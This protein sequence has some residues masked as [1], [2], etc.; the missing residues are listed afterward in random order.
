MLLERVLQRE[1]VHHRR[2]HAHIVGGRAVEALGRGGHAAEDVAAADDEAQ[3]MALRLRRCDLAGEAGDRFGIDAELA[4]AH[5]RLARQLQQDAVEARAGHAGGCV[6]EMEQGRPR[7]YGAAAL[8]PTAKQRPA[9]FQATGS[10][11]LVPAAAATSAAKS[12]SF[13]SM[14]S[15]SWKRTKPFSLIGVAGLLRGRRDDVGDRGL[16]VDHEQL[17]EQRILLAELGDGALDHLVDDVCGLAALRRLFRRDRALALDQLA[18][19]RSSAVSAS[20]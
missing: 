17:G 20:G 16:V 3:L 8:L 14:P 15:P 13:F 9:A 1:R 12:L 11:L 2:Q 7:L 18:G 5:Q 19:S 6:L 10:A 4:L